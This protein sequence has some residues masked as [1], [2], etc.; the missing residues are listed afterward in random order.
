M[1]Q[2]EDRN[3][4]LERLN[5]LRRTPQPV[6]PAPASYRAPSRENRKALT[7]WQDAAAV[8]QLKHLAAELGVTQQA[9]IAEG[10]NAV[11]AKY[12]KPTVAT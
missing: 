5:P 1:K 3:T 8:K 9:L 12:G 2:P 4:W 10:I 6:R 7:T 11:L